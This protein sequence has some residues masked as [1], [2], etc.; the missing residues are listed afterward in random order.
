MVLVD[1][2][3]SKFVMVKVKGKVAPVLVFKFSTTP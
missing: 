3:N 1:L 2:L